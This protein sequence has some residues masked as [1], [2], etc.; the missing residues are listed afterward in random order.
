[1]SYRIGQ[2][3]DRHRL[4]AGR[5]CVL[6]GVLFTESQVGPEGHSDGDAVLHAVTDAAL[7]AAGLGDIG[8][9]FP[10]TDERFKD[11][12]SL[13]LLRRAWSLVREQGFQLGNVDLTI[14][15]EA[16]RIAPRVLAMRQILGEALGT[17]L[18]RV[19]VKATCGEGLGPE[20]RG[21]CL[22][23][24]AVILLESS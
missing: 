1:M 3:W 23:V 4:V 24:Q 2:G 19:S 18:S 9:H 5:P 21:E 14:I 11:A 16:P 20:G 8:T 17:D 15:A 6:G 22:T 12:D 10:D 7:G 13:D